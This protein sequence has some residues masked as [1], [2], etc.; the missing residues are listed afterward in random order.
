M[1][2]SMKAKLGAS[3]LIGFMCASS[4]AFSAD[5][6]I[7]EVH[8]HGERPTEEVVDQSMTGQD[9]KKVKMQY[10]VRYEDLD[11]TTSDGVKALRNRVTKAALQACADLGRR[12][13]NLRPDNSCAA[14]A[15]RTANS[16]IDLAIEQ[17][18]SMAALKNA[19]L[20]ADQA[21]AQTDSDK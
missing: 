12:Y 1:N 9:I 20:E 21:I 6:P 4:A 3:L 19:T 18:R 11:L 17:A 5:Q 10:H 14:A 8:S 7:E 13:G 15:R 16:Q 2:S